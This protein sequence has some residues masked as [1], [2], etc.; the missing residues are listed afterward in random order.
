MPSNPA[1]RDCGKPNSR[2]SQALSI[3]SGV[4]VLMAG[5]RPLLAG[6]RAIMVTLRGILRAIV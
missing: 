2:A 6:L 3:C 1:M 5:L 4:K